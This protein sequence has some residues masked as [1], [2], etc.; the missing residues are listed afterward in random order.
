MYIIKSLF[1]VIA[2]F[3]SAAL[4]EDYKEQKSN[5]DTI[6]KI[7]RLPPTEAGKADDDCE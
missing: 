3:S 7:N 5:E 1:I 4:A 6:E 2:I